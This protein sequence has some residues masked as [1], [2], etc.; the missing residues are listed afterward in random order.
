MIDKIYTNRR[1][2]PALTVN[3]YP[4][5]ARQVPSEHV[6]AHALDFLALHGDVFRCVDEPYLIAFN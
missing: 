4:M 1:L 5:Q 3:R 6:R 2:S